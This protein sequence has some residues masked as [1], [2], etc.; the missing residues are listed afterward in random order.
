MIVFF[1]NMFLKCD[2]LP[3]LFSVECFSQSVT[4]IFFFSFLK[5]GCCNKSRHSEA[6]RSKIMYKVK[7]KV[8]WLLLFW[9]HKLN[10]Q[11]ALTVSEFKLQ[12]NRFVSLTMLWILDRFPN[13]FAC[14]CLPSCFLQDTGWRESFYFQLLG[15]QMIFLPH[16][17]P[18][19]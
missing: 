8:E 9:N 13:I 1:D 19:F 12:S 11:Q 18:S 14:S 16:S 17:L 7:K 3:N 10:L 2:Y 5:T 6:F 4:L 15:F